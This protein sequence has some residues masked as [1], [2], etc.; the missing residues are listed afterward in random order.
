MPLRSGLAAGVTLAA[1]SMTGA[2]ASSPPR[3]ASTGALTTYGYDNARSGHDTVDPTVHGLSANPSW[4]A[5]LDGSV[6]GQPLVY[7]GDVFVATENDS[8]Y[9]LSASTG[10]VAWRLHVGSTVGVAVV[11]TAPTLSGG[12]GDIDPL[13]I[14][15][16]PVID[17][18]TNVLYAAEETYVGASKWQDI[19]HWLVA[20]SLTTHRELW[21]RGI[22]PPGGNQASHYYIPA[23]QQRPALTFYKNH[24]YVEFGGLSGD[25]GAYHGYVVGVPSGSPSGP[26]W[27]YQVPTQREG[28]IWGT[29]GAAVTATGDLYVATG[30]GNSNSLAHFDEGNSVVELSPSLLRLGYYAP[31][32]WVQLNNADWDLGSAGPIVVPNTSLL[33]AAGKPSNTTTV[34][35]L[36]HDKL[37][38]IGHGAVSAPACNGGGVY[39]A[40][41]S[42]VLGSGASAKTFLY[43][44]CGGGTEAIEVHVTAP[45]SFHEVWQ[46]STGS[47]NGSPIVAGGFV[48]AL[49]W[50][51]NILYAMNPTTGHVV[52][53]RSTAGWTTSW[54]PRSATASS[55]CRRRAVSRPS[56]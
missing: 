54:H 18:A 50:N 4:D 44:A 56:A 37:G 48:W 25:C 21:H 49:D 40:D 55:W 26:L 12:C 6:Y 32:N 39:G 10:H 33:F 5:S 3:S 35:Y 22:D 36:M 46:P 43:L 51:A 29:G 14:T 47:P 38:G 53:S 19:R 9:A 45:L 2:G 17:T 27:S 52:F 42:D 20:I 30:N 15:G 1:A 7:K 8:V 23:E 16:T 34:G 13:G 24:V 28:G 11:D 31:A 41:A